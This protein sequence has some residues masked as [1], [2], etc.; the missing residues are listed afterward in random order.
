MD[1]RL[2]LLFAIDIHH[3]SVRGGELI[4][5]LEG[6]PQSVRQR[7]LTEYLDVLVNILELRYV[8]L[9]SGGQCLNLYSALDTKPC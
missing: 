8:P 6:D 5:Q 7:C 9:D 2:S 4:G 1:E 3:H